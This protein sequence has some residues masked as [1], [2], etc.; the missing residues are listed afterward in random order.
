[1]RKAAFVL[2]LLLVPFVLV[3][4]DSHSLRTFFPSQSSGASI[5]PV[6]DVIGQTCSAT[7]TEEHRCLQEMLGDGYSF[8]WTQRCLSEETR[9]ALV[10]LFDPWFSKNLP[11]RDALFSV[12]VYNEDGSCGINARIGGSCMAFVLKDSRIV[13]MKEL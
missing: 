11:C 8:E 2:A 4:E 1:M 7:E 12:A 9:S 5:L 13:M 6:D 3:A 10:R